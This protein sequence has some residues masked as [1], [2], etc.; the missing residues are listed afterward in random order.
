[1]WESCCQHTSQRA[2]FS[3]GLPPRAKLFFIDTMG[4]CSNINTSMPPT[5]AMI[6]QPLFFNQFMDHGIGILLDTQ[7]DPLCLA[8]PFLIL[9]Q[10]GLT[11][12]DL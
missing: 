6:K 9:E 7:D 12:M 8:T 11:K 3:N 2:N 4:M 10:L 5:A 1:L